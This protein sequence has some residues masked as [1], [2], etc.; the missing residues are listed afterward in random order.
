MELV[1]APPPEWTLGAL[2]TR[3]A[4]LGLRCTIVMIDGTLVMPNVPPPPRFDDV[5]LKTPAGTLALKRRSDGVAVVAF[6]NA[7]AA[8]QAAQQQIVDALNTLK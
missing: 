7:D 2:L 1:A 4:Q 6:G 3:L 5:R 8:L